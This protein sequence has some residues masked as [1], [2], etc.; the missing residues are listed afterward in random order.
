M[1]EPRRDLGRPRGEPIERAIL[2]ATVA[3]LAAV[4]LDGL[5]VPRVAEAAGVNK[6]TVYRRWPTREALVAAALQAA[7]HETAEAVVDTGS[8]RG[9]LSSLL[10][11]VAARMGSAEG[12]ALVRAGLSEQAAELVGAIARDPVVRQQSA[13]VLTVARAAARGEWDPC[14]HPPEAVLA[15]LTGAVMHR[16]LMERQ[17]V[18]PEWS[19]AVVDV[20]VRGLARP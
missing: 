14:R 18:T 3:E 17:P 10:Q 9:D 7:L 16:L 15:M 8:L 20:I 5:S 11:L 6:T 19:E 12:R 13:V 1:S 4:G 2:A